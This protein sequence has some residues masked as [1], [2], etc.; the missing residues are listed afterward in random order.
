MPQNWPER[1]EKL[2]YIATSLTAIDWFVRHVPA[3]VV[4]VTI[5]I[6]RITY[7]KAIVTSEVVVFVACYT[8]IVTRSTVANGPRDALLYAHRVVYK[9]GRIV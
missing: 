9:G 2:Q 6:S 5:V 4:T 1:L 7:T 8:F 3:V